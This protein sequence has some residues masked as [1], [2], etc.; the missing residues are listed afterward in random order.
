MGHIC[1]NITQTIG[2]TPLVRLNRMVENSSCE[3]LA[4]LEFFNPLSSVKDRIGLSLIDDGEQRG[5][6]EPGTVIIEPTSGNTG[7]A[8]AFIC[9]ARGYRL[10]LTM[11]EAMS[12]E[13]RKMFQLLGAELVVTPASEGMRGAI[14]KAKELHA[15]IPH[16]FIPNQF[17][18]PANPRAHYTTTGPEIWDDCDGQ[19]DGFVVGVGT[20]GTLTGAGRFLKE[21]NPNLRIYAVEPEESPVLSGGMP[22]PHRIQGI[23]AGFIPQVLDTQLIHRICKVSDQRAF[24]VARLMAQRE[25]IPCGISSGATVAAAM[26]MAVL[27]ENQ[28]KRLVVII[29]SF[30]ER[31]F[32]SEL[33]PE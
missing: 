1:Q 12:V 30:A 19:V 23:G 4:K 3:I 21:K 17:D 13:R 14:E 10:I 6:I 24:E 32:S 15:K 22:G 33:F 26:D 31:Y 5:W 18:N 20:G 25:G 7:I 2:R 28:G 8:L 27:P 16:S 29:A 9:A 11:P